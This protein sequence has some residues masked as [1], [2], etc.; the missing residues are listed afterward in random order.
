MPKLLNYI[1]LGLLF[2]LLVLVRA[3]E[4]ELFYDPYLEFFKNDYLYMDNPR[5]EVA[6]L[7]AFTTMRYLINSVL[8]LGIILLLFKDRSLVRFAGDTLFGCLYV[9]NHT[10]FVFRY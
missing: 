2:V 3:F 9:I 10:V 8:S 5:R 4:G 1:L 6:K 7:I